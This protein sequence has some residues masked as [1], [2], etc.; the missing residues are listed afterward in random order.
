MNVVHSGLWDGNADLHYQNFVK[1]F[2]ALSYILR[3]FIVVVMKQHFMPK[4]YPKSI[5]VPSRTLDKGNVVG[6]EFDDCCCAPAEGSERG[7]CPMRSC[8]C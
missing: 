2:I 6:T 7:A 5:E 3:W 4:V 8:R 1:E